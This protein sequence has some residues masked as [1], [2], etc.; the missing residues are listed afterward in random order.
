ME[1]VVRLAAELDLQLIAEG[2]E[3]CAERQLLMEMGFELAQGFLFASPEP[4][5]S[6]LANPDHAPLGCEGS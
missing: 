3:S 5:D 1:A 2:V 4:I 6:I